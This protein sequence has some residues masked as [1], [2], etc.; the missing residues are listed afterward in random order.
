MSV[1][2]YI[3]GAGGSETSFNFLRHRFSEHAP[4][5]FSYD[6]S[7]PV[8][9]CIGRLSQMIGNEQHSAVLIG[10]S[11]GGIIARGCGTLHNVTHLVTLCAPFGGIP[12]A[13]FLAVFNRASIYSDL[14]MFSPLLTQLRTRHINAPHLP[15]VASRGL[16]HIDQPNDG[17]ITVSSQTA[18][19]GLNYLNLKLNHF[20]VLMSD[21]VASTIASFITPGG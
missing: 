15:I 7:E 10:H 16:P 14:R 17:V 18:I 3:H 12:Y 11:L 21:Y 1:I 4:R 20:E 13:E 8:E 2:W 9:S 19:P 5:F 6:V